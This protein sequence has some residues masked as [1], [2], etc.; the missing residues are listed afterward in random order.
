[1]VPRNTT[2]P[3]YHELDVSTLISSGFSRELGCSCRFSC[4]ANHFQLEFQ[5]LCL[6][7]TTKCTHRTQILDAHLVIYSI[8]GDIPGQI[9]SPDLPDLPAHAAGVGDIQ[10]ACMY[11]L[12]HVSWVGSVLHR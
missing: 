8:N 12:G 9:E 3:T 4:A 7:G 2:C 10:A 5:E 11:D 6:V 1:M